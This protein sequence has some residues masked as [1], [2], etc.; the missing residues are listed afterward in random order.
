MIVAYSNTRNTTQTYYLDPDE[1]T[2]FYPGYEVSLNENEIRIFS[3]DADQLYSTSGRSTLFDINTFYDACSTGYVNRYEITTT[4]IESNTGTCSG[5]WGVEDGVC[6]KVPANSC[7]YFIID[8]ETYAKL[9]MNTDI[10]SIYPN[11]ASNFFTLLYTDQEFNT[12][13]D[14]KIDIYSIAGA[15]Q[16]TSIINAGA[17]VDIS[18]LPVGVY[19]LNISQN[20]IE[21]ENE[22]LVKMK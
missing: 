21:Q 5:A 12:G 13:D 20:G 10:Y 19:L 11:P 8:M 7:G 22:I 16:K 2:G 14:V 4:S 18:D 15:F 6:V 17:N 3:V 1:V 9:G